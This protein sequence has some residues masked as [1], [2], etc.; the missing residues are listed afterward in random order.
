MR[1]AGIHPQDF[2]RHVLRHLVH[3]FIGCVAFH[4][5][6]AVERV[7]V[8]GDVAAGA[9]GH[10]ADKG[11]I[12]PVGTEQLLDPNGELSKVIRRD[13]GFGSAGARVMQPIIGEQRDRPAAGGLHREEI[14]IGVDRT[15]G[16]VPVRMTRLVRHDPVLLAERICDRL[17]RLEQGAPVEDMLQHLAGAPADP[18]GLEVV[19][20]TPDAIDD[21]TDHERLVI[22]GRNAGAHR[23]GAARTTV[24]VGGGHHHVGGRDA[25]GSV[26]EALGLVKALAAEADPI[27]HREDQLGRAVIEHEAAHVQLVV[28][29]AGVRA[30]LADAA[31]QG[32]DVACRRPGLEHPGRRGRR[33]R[34]EH[35]QQAGCESSK[36]PVQHP[37]RTTGMPK[38]AGLHESVRDGETSP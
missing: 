12:R 22:V 23:I 26:K 33:R 24:R 13:V 14:D 30:V 15:R 16:L 1:D 19:V 34:G 21:A 4:A 20:C 28:D 25:E 6:L 35:Q 2:L 9:V 5:R 11:R 10:Q 38:I 3:L 32:G 18:G 27:D 7:I 17:A 8:A 36:G 29:V 37:L 31:Q